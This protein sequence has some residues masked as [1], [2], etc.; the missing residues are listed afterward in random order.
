MIASVRAALGGLAFLA[1]FHPMT[2]YR[3]VDRLGEPTS[4]IGV[5]VA[6]IGYAIP[7]LIPPTAWTHIAGCVQTLL[8]TALFFI[9]DNRAVV[10]GEAILKA[11]ADALPSAYAQPLGLPAS[12][13]GGGGAVVTLGAA[14]ITSA[15]APVPNS[16]SGFAA[17]SMLG[18]LFGVGMLGLLAMSL[19]GCGTQPAGTTSTVQQVQTISSDLACYSQAVANATTAGF[20]AA[21]DTK[22]AAISSAASAASGALCTGLAVGT[23]L[24]PAAS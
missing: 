6:I 2:P 17:R 1:R 22:N 24:A 11:V 20:T 18:L 15:P 23:P 21:G 12:A 14:T 19:T 9:P 10:T 13:T 8:G 16:Q 3:I 5:L 7:L 4:W